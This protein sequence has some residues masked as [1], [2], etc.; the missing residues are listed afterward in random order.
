M[1]AVVVFSF[2]AAMSPVIAGV[3]FHVSHWIVSISY[4]YQIDRDIAKA[5]SSLFSFS[6][7]LSHLLS[8]FLFLSVS[9]FFHSFSCISAG[10]FLSLLVTGWMV[11]VQI[12]SP[13][14]M[15]CQRQ[16]SWRSHVARRASGG[17]SGGAVSNLVVERTSCTEEATW[18][19]FW[20]CCCHRRKRCS[21][22]VVVQVLVT[23]FSPR[24]GRSESKNVIVV[25][26][27][28]RNTNHSRVQGKGG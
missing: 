18:G 27:R 24:G 4:K 1:L 5:T 12:G 15:G 3:I 7:H 23:G 19:V 6:C 2:H 8:P 21:P 17:S 25:L 9:L 20:S 10:K 11:F 26:F 22:I 14:T 13:G 16:K 28:C